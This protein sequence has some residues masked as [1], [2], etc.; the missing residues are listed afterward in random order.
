MLQDDLITKDA[1]D[2]YYNEVVIDL[3][4]S[5]NKR[6]IVESNISEQKKYQ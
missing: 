4:K 5:I 3:H 1:Y 2:K 6:T